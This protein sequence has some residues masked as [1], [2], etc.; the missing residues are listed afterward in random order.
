M[1]A[2]EALLAARS[3]HARIEPVI[4]DGHVEWACMCGELLGRPNNHEAHIAAEQAKALREW[5]TSDET[6]VAVG[7]ALLR[8]GRMIG[9]PTATGGAILAALA[10]LIGAES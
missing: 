8:E 2:V 10:D 4:T 1:N 9:T 6:Q 5:L 7:A 3:S